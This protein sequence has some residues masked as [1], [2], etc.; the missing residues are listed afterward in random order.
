MEGLNKIEH[1]AVRVLN[2]VIKNRVTSAQLA[3]AINVAKGINP[4]PIYSS[5]DTKEPVQHNIQKRKIT[6]SLGFD[7]DQPL[8][9]AVV[10]P[11]PP[12]FPL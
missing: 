9:V 8:Q 10:F 7:L 1:N 5:P 6:G 3:K 11:V 2:I 4:P 12:Q